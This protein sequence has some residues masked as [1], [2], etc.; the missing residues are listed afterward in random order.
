LKAEQVQGAIAAGQRADLLLLD[1]NPL[2]DIRDTTKIHA[3]VPG[4][5]LLDRAA[6]DAMLAKAKETAAKR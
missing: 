2:D 5:Q 4:G 1:A 3:V 6:L